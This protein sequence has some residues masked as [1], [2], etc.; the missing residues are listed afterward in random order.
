MLL[1]QQLALG[2]ARERALAHL[3]EGGA[4][5]GDG[6]HRVVD[7]AAAEPCLRDHEALAAMPEQVVLRDANVRVANVAVG[8]FLGP[9]A[10][11]DVADDLNT[12][13]L[14]RHQEHGHLV[15][16]RR[17]RVGHHHDD[18]E[19]GVARVRGEP[20][21]AVDHPLVAVEHGL[22]LEHLGVG[23]AVRLGHR[24]GRDDLVVEQRLKEARLL[25]VR[26]VVGEDLRIARVRRL[27]TEGD[28]RVG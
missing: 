23:A 22:G 7:A 19:G 13:R 17:L 11:A 27:A 10:D 14:L 5:L 28:R 18:Q 20:L 6:A 4:H 8:S 1:R 21:L 16:G 2:L 15:V 24:V 12:R 3:V 9:R 25:R 26:A